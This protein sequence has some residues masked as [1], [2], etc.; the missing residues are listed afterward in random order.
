MRRARHQILIFHRVVREPD[1]MSPGEPTAGWFRALVRRLAADFEVIPLADAV[2]RSRAGTLRGG[3][4]SLTFDDGY[5]DNVEVALPILEEAGVPATFFVASGFVDGGRMWNDSIIETFRRL[6]AGSHAIA[7]DGADTR[8]EL[9]GWESRRDAAA[10]V[11]TAWKHLPQPERQ[12]RVAALASRVRGLPDDLMMSSA[13][14][15]ALAASPVATVGGHTRTHPILTT[16]PPAR[17]REEITGG[18]ADLEGAIQQAVTLFAYPN[19]KRGRDY[20]AGHARLVADAGFDAAVATDWG[21]LE[22][23]TDPYHIP[24]FTPWHSNLTRFSLDLA[25][26]HHGLLGRPAT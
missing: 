14:L 4:L 2:E 15:R 18:K 6:P 8:I 16:L 22:P 7:L 20:D 12:A 3:S 23:G 11:V 19:G 21:S 10:R 13:Q 24:R 26:C 9:A 1:P 25:R 5:A 17:A